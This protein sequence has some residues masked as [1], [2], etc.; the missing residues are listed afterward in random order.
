MNTTG[1]R[2]KH[3][4]ITKTMSRSAWP[5]GGAALRAVCPLQFITICWSFTMTNC[6]TRLQFCGRVAHT[7]QSCDAGPPPFQWPRLPIT[8]RTPTGLWKSV[9]EWVDVVTLINHINLDLLV[10]GL[11]VMT[12]RLMK[13]VNFSPSASSLRLLTIRREEEEEKQRRR[14]VTKAHNQDLAANWMSAFIND[15]PY[16]K[17]TLRIRIL[18]D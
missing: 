6:P 7:Q 9:I 1:R 17:K 2:L 12:M 10:G 3:P 11:K 15:E 16:E 18:I 13:W 14:G 8:P 5:R 4:R